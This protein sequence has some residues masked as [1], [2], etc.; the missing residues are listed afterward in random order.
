M[1]LLPVTPLTFGVA[2]AAVL[3]AVFGCIARSPESGAAAQSS[4]DGVPSGASP[5]SATEGDVEQLVRF[6]KKQG[7][8]LRSDLDKAN[9]KDKAALARVFRFSLNFKSLDQNARTYGQLIF[10]SLINLAEVMGR[11]Q[12]SEV[13][14]AQEPRVRQRIRDLLYSRVV[15]SV[16]EKHRAEVEKEVRGD[17]PKLFPN[18]YQFGHDDPLFQK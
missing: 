4:G 6:A 9:E 18:D 1:R 2:V 15:L 7:V 11:E 17:F 16:P 8:D 13:V 14:V 5:N 3:V 10:N 12:Y